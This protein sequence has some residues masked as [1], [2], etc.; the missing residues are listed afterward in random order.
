MSAITAE[1][2]KISAEYEDAIQQARLCVTSSKSSSSSS[3]TVSEG[4]ISLE[5][6]FGLSE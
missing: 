6:F 3:I 1:I 4:I 5:E 2:K